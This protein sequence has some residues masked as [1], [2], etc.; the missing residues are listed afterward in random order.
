MINE[1]S[2]IR[3]AY[4]RGVIAQNPN[5]Q[6]IHEQ[7]KSLTDLGI[8]GDTDE[9]LYHLAARFA[10]AEAVS[11]LKDSGIKPAQ[12]K[13]GNTALH[14]L[15]ASKFD[16]KDPEIEVKAQAIYATAKLLLEAGVNPKKKNDAG[17]LA[18][19]DA[20]SS[21]MYPLVDALADNGV[22]MD[23]T[24]SEGKNLLHDISDKLTHRKS[25]PGALQAATNTIRILLQKA[26]LDPE[27][28]D[29]FGT[30]ALTY[31]Q[32]S[33]V[34]EIA[35]LLSGDE[36]DT[37]TAGMT[38]HEAVLHKDIEAV[39]AL[40]ASGAD[41][42]EMSDSYKRTP[43]MLACEYPSAPMVDLLISHG[44][45]VNFT[46]GSGE[47]ATYFLLTKGI[48]NFGRGMS[49]QLKDMV[50]IL[51]SLTNA[52]LDTDAVISNEGD[53]ALN[54]LC[55]AGYL[56]DLNADLAEVLID[57]GCDI[58]K[59]NSRGLTPL[60]SFAGK[61]NEPKYGIAELLLDNNADVNY[62]DS[63]GTTALM[64]AAANQDHASAKRM[65]SLILDA[66]DSG[67]DKVNNTGQT[68]LDLAIQNNNDAVVK[69]LLA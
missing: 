14:A 38:L 49:Q 67:K 32:R 19:F 22:R 60:M 54:V 31:A 47:T 42:N 45:D 21:Y 44:V 62:V 34:K 26:G 24:D 68:A 41:L 40:C 53:T 64:H 10:D 25:I 23:A 16:L 59:P 46:A 1:F 56:A 27:D 48:N 29:I 36:S 33:G 63:T 28:K 9:D 43:L 17:K 61:G 50:A 15:A 6:A 11:F 57:A 66:D 4:H 12:D 37:I 39:E 30:T 7:Y 20:G 65:V 5:L 2:Q 8:K 58:N 51:R 3:D 55:Q 18:Y 13:Y 35:A 69:L 52:G